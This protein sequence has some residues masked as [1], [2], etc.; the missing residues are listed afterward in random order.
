MVSGRRGR[1]LLADDEDAIVLALARVLYQDNERYDVLLARTG[2]IARQ[3]MREIEIDVLVTD[4]RMPGIS[5]LDLL[6]WASTE[7][8]ATRVIV[9]T[10]YDVAASQERAYRLGCLSFVP[11]P[12]DLHEMRAKVLELF[13]RRDAGLGGN[14]ADLSP[15]DVVQMLCLGRKSTVLRV[16]AGTDGGAVYLREGEIVHA[17]WNDLSGEE[18]FYRLV[19]ASSGVFNTLP[20]PERTPQT[21]QT[22]WQHLLLEG[23]RLQDEGALGAVEAP[24][25]APSHRRDKRPTQESS[26]THDA[27]E[28]WKRPPGPH[29]IARLI[30]EG[31]NAMREGDFPTARSKWEEALVLDPDNRM[32]Q[33]NLRRLEQNQRHE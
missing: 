5:G 26:R 23:M 12:F 19:C 27:S 8:P 24:A 16:V 18:A 14:L 28:A 15:A 20:C 31:F 22:G 21:I 3:V 9:M 10:S 13:S 2:E 1:V 6:C 32:V 7:S 17:V 30:D 25:P 4:V 11:K 33:L 29:E